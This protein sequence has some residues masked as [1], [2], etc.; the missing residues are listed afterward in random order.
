MKAK[1]SFTAIV[2]LVLMTSAAM[3]AIGENINQSI[4]QSASQNIEGSTIIGSSVNQGIVQGASQGT[5]GTGTNASFG[6]NQ[7]INQNAAQNIQGSNINGSSVNQMI[8]QGAAQTIEGIGNNT[9]FASS[10]N[11][12]QGANQNLQGVSL[13]NAS[14]NQNI[15][16]S[17]N[18]SY[19]TMNNQPAAMTEEQRAALMPAIN[20]FLASYPNNRMFIMPME[21]LDAFNAAGRRD[22]VILNVGS[23][24]IPSSFSSLPLITI[25]IDQLAVR[26]NEIP[27]G[28]AIAVI[29]DN[30]MASATAATLLRMQGFN[31]WAVKT[32]IC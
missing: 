3:A 11:I 32:G 22:V 17:A 4:S 8:G 27:L 26:A 24:A 29:G 13:F 31:A 28:A 30:D 9:G 21:D 6:S 20:D 15:A 10:Q 5:F 23:G 14:L 18:Q 16:Q 25:P 2:L 12:A 7:N 19:F 1:I